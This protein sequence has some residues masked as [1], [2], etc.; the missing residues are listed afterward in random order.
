MAGE[1]EHR[2]PGGGDE[3]PQLG[4]EQVFTSVDDV[5]HHPGRQGEEEH[6]QAAG[7]LYQRDIQRIGAQAQH[8]PV[9]TD[10]AHP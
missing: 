1:G 3:H 4:E 6:W 10:V 9:N 7:R 5:R 8:A 2:Q